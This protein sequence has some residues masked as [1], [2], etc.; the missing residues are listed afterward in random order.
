MV[1]EI[2][3][4][5]LAEIGN[6][7]DPPGTNAG[8]DIKRYLGREYRP[9]RNWCAGF[10][11]YCL[12]KAGFVAPVQ[13]RA[14]RGAKPFVRYVAETGEWVVHSSMA[15]SAR[16]HSFIA[17]SIQPGDIICWN[18]SK[19]ITWKGHVAVVE[20]VDPTTGIMTVVDPNVGSK[21]E[22]TELKPA[23]W[24]HRQAGLYGV[25]RAAKIEKPEMH[26]FRKRPVTIEAYQTDRELDIETLEGTMRARASDW[27]ITGVNGEQYPCRDDIF[28]KTYE[29]VD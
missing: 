20:A 1:N 16:K 10:G 3:R 15:L 13:G 22:R 4:V 27:I 8:P 6:G 29:L 2:V 18:R 11:A 28:Q 23:E 21:V 26:K 17:L 14:K 24:L 19:L 7:E 9:G 5:A 25:A 12:A